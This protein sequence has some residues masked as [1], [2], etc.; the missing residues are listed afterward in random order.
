MT[1]N[2]RCPVC[3]SDR[4]EPG[5]LESTGRV[6]FRPDHARFLKAE[7][8]NVEVFGLLC[9]QCG[10]LTLLKDGKSTARQPESA[11]FFRDPTS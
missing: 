11:A 2:P 8:T 3:G 1:Q 9:M 5:R 7:T 6:H 4:V 10:N